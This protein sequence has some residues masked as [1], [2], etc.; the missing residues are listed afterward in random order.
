MQIDADMPDTNSLR[1]WYQKEGHKGD[2]KS[3]SGGGG[4]GGLRGAG[5]FKREE[6]KTL[7]EVRESD[8]GTHDA[9]DYFTSRASIITIKH[10][11]I[12]YPACM[13]ENC[14]KKVNDT[15]NGWHCEKCEK[16]WPKPE[17]RYAP[18][19]DS[20]LELYHPPAIFLGFKL[21]IIQHRRGFRP[22]TMSGWILSG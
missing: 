1:G 16:T 15:G 12:A 10:E 20:V 6:L 9:A 11:N 22:S 14:N 8:M 13:G 19:P 7:L 18:S 2:F 21:Q 17:Y 3:H 5:G 4:G